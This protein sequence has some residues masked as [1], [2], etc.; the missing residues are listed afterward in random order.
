MRGDIEPF[1]LIFFRHPQTKDHIGELDNHETRHRRPG[2]N[3]QHANRLH[4]KLLADAKS[5]AEREKQEI[6]E[7]VEQWKVAHPE[8]CQ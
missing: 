7:F 6:A 3:R 5:E 2:G 4:P 1:D 8:W